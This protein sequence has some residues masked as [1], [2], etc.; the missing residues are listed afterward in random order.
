MPAGA[1]AVRLQ[2][3]PAGDA[4]P[5]ITRF[6]SEIE[7]SII[8]QTRSLTMSY[9]QSFLAKSTATLLSNYHSQPE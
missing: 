7:S 6:H 4:A 1:G 5:D 9:V 8:I 2:R 3:G